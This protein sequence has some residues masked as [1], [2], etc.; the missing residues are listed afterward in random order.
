MVSES[1]WLAGVPGLPR[2][3]NT[4]P[5]VTVN[6]VRTIAEGKVLWFGNAGDG[7]AAVNTG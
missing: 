5:G 7:V 2:Y 6:A 4:A 1:T 3:Q